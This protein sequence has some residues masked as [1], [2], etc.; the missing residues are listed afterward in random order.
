LKIYCQ[1]TEHGLVPLYP[2]DL[3]EKK[4]LKKNQVYSCEITFERNYEFHKKFFALCKIGC[5]NSKNV[6]MPLD[7]YRRYATIKAGYGEIYHTPKGLFVDA[8]SIKF[9]SMTQEE[10][11]KVYSDVLNFIIKDTKAEKEFIE[12]ELINFM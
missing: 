2:S 3:E 9:A 12:N 8:K 7:A 11:E 10:F 6:E 5:E 1:N 4:K